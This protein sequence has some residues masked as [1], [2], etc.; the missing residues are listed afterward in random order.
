MKQNSKSTKKQ[1]NNVRSVA[2][3]VPIDSAISS[4]PPLTIREN[5]AILI[6]AISFLVCGIIYGAL[7]SGRFASHLLPDR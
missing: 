1:K 2:P 5:Q 7:L 6:P 4:A 3:N